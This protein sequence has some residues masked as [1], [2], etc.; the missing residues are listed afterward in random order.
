M[1]TSA[2]SSAK[3]K[4]PEPDSASAAAAAATRQQEKQRRRRRAKQR[5]N[6]GDESAD[7]NIEVDPDWD[8]PPGQEPV[9]STTVSDRGARPLGFAGTVSK[10]GA[11][12]AGLA[13]LAGDEFGGGPR[14]PIMPYTWDDGEVESSESELSAS[15]TLGIRR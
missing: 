7:M 9:A 10:T 1:G 12:A 5:G 3:K 15:K 8:V 14:E 2:S 4:A 13:T 11:T 6:G